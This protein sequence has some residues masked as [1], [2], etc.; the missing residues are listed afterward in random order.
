[1]TIT[2]VIEVTIQT[3]LAFFSILFFTRLLGK[4]QIAQ[5]SF[6]DYVN[7]ITFGSIAAVLATDLSQRTW[8][9]L[10]GLFLFALLT[11]LM[12]W[13]TIKSRKAR[14]VIEG[15]PLVLVHNGKILEDNMKKARFN[16]KELA[17][18][19]RKNNLFDVDQVEYAILE[20]DGS[21]SVMPKPEYR[22][23]TPQDMGLSFA[24]EAIP[25]TIIIEGKLLTPN[26]KQHNLNRVWIKEQLQSH[27]VD[28]IQDVFMASYDP[29]KQKLYIDLYDDELGKDKV[30]ISEEMN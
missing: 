16:L 2:A 13:I 8:Q 17:A 10:I 11:F 29:S 14:K 21:L 26:L 5:L 12:E 18:Q 1:M 30:D 3:F 22:S 23:L 4:Q 6:H 20:T 24:P 9:H 28:D 25:A 19:L 27:G 15:E 7:G